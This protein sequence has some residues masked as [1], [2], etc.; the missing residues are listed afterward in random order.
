MWLHFLELPV[1]MRVLY[2]GVLCVLALGYCMAIGYV[3]ESHASRDGNAMLSSQDLVLAYSGSNSDTRLEAALSGP[4]K[5]MLPP[6]E[7][8]VIVGW[9]HG[10]TDKATFEGEVQPIMERRCM[11]CHDGSNPHLPNLK[12]YQNTMKMVE[13]DTGMTIATLIRVSHIHLL[14]ITFLFF[15]MGLIFS[16]AYVRPLW[17]K[18]V[19]TGAPFAALIV[20]IASWYLTKVH[21]GFA[22]VVMGSGL[23]V[24]ACVAIMFS[25][26]I[27]QMW[28]YSMPD[29]LKNRHRQAQQLI[30]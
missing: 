1:S 5:G 20:D 28:F 18:W 16:H 10:D 8:G 25:I 3:F 4:M 12:G 24:A 7:A 21:P 6:E 15:I 2:T 22:W 13:I 27:W 17:F 26:S 30:N 19:T 9:I 29:E 11:S 14:G 23:V